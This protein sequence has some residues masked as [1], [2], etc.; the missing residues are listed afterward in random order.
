MHARHGGS[1]AAQVRDGYHEAT[2]GHDS[3]S[4]LK[5]AVCACGVP[6]YIREAN[7]E[8]THACNN[9]CNGI[10]AHDDNIKA[11]RVY[12]GCY[13]VALTHNSDGK[14]VRAIRAHDTNYVPTCA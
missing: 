8:D 10:C 5:C 6:A 9:N 12:D 1:K 4:K 7:K 2:R 13:V 14:I 11:A 3:D